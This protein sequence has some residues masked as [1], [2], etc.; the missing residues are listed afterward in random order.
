MKQG[1]ELRMI[2][3]WYLVREQIAPF[4]F[5]FSVIMFLLV[6]DTILQQVDMILGRGVS[7]EVATELFFL[8]TAWQVALAVPMSV[9]AGSLMAFGRL[10]GDNEI[11]AMRSLG[12]SIVGL[13]LPALLAG[14]ILALLLV[15]FND[16]VLPDF[17][18]RARLLTMDIKRKRP[19][20]AFQDRAG[21]LIDNFRDYHILIGE[22][23]ERSGL[24]DVVIYKYEQV[25]YPLTLIADR[26]E[27]EFS[28]SDEVFL[29]LLDGHVHRLDDEKSD[30]FVAGEFK[31]LTLKLGE[32]GRYLSRTV[33]S[34]RNDRE[35]DMATMWSKVAAY[36]ATADSLRLEA[37]TRWADFVERVLWAGEGRAAGIGDTQ[38]LRRVSSRVTSDITLA[39][40]KSRQAGRLRVEIHKKVSIP[41]ACIVF[42][43]VGAPLGI[44]V[45]RGGAATGAALSIGFFLVYWVFLILGEKLA[46]RAVIP[47]WAAMWSPNILLGLV[48]TG[49]ISWL[50]RR[51]R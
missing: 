8:H 32:G 48:G 47:P 26:G 36:E 13:I 30:V 4:L 21:I 7:W 18:H 33:S 46:D 25:G 19:T 40:H 38:D 23:D 9:L 1:V 24:K 2:L 3:R 17:N 28:G 12:V 16:R 37:G 45:R 49:L 50:S 14:T 31:K 41:V 10:S 22:V 27:I 6:L 15:F 34:Y 42:V 39:G 44:S 43:M 51:G 5:S 35:M 29:T 20:V 11:V